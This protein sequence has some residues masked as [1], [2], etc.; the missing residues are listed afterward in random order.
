MRAVATLQTGSKNPVSSAPLPRD[1]EKAPAQATE[2]Q[3]TMVAGPGHN[4]GTIKVNSGNSFLAS[5]IRIQPKLTINQPGDVYEQ[6]ADAVADR[7]MRMPDVPPKLSGKAGSIIQRKCSHCEEEEGKKVQRKESS[8]IPAV[9]PSTANYIGSL[10]GG[11]SLSVGERGFFEPR[12]GH[13]LSR[14]RL[15]TDSRAAESARG[16]SALAYTNGSNIVFG[17]GQYQP[18]TDSG[19]RL[20]AHELVHTVQQ[21]GGHFKAVKHDSH[22]LD[23]NSL[24]LIR[25][26]S[27]ARSQ[28]QLVPARAVRLTII[29]GQNNQAEF[30][31]TRTEGEPLSASGTASGIDPGFYQVSS[32]TSR[33][34]M[35]IQTADGLPLPTTTQFFIDIPRSA[36]Q[37]HRLLGAAREPIAMEVRTGT[38]SGSP[39]VGGDPSSSTPTTPSEQEVGQLPEQVRRV[40]FSSTATQ[41]VRPTDYP[42][43]LRIGLKLM[44]LSDSELEAYRA[45]TTS[46]T[47]DLAVFEASVDRYL[48]EVLQRRQAVLERE[49]IKQQLF[50]LDSVYGQYRSYRSLLTTTSISAGAGAMGAGTALGSQPTLNRMRDDLTANLQRYG[51]SSIAVFE[52]TIQTFE[53]AFR[54]EAVLIARDMLDRYEHVLVEQYERYQNTAETTNLHQQLQPARQHYQQANQIREDHPDMPYTPDEAAASDYWQG[55]FREAQFQG[56]QSVSGLASTQPLLAD[57]SMSAETLAL[58]GPD[59]IQS[60][61]LGY[62]RDR[63]ADVA[64]TRRN[65]VSTPDMI[66]ELPPLLQAAYREQNIQPGSIYHQIIQH[67]ISERH[68]QQMILSLGLAVFALAAGLLSGGTGTVAVL[69]AGTA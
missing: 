21:S 47:T 1:A 36:V 48:A 61:M 49:Q 55:Q 58:T 37:L 44:G 15:H 19:K 23:S 40:L 65:L 17:A 68:T 10:S 6:E 18:E 35:I 13:D 66:F 50:G 52:Q 12:I 22:H 67:H 60:F 3:D 7:M 69:G 46:A 33:S 27:V 45:R 57:R 34:A 64:T 14:V 25:A 2:S 53:T 62:I 29:M 63:R 56:Q 24:P 26:N 32:R 16:I 30:V 54:S 31:M 20:L 9:L 5:P 4:F 28:L 42:D 59:R 38:V 43:L 41:Q 8:S 11:R 39:P 51:F